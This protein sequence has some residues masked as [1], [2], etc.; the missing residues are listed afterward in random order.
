MPYLGQSRLVL[1]VR[2][3]ALGL[4]GLCRV[5]VATAPEAER[6]RLALF[7][8]A[9]SRHSPAFACVS[10]DACLSNARFLCLEV[11]WCLAQRACRWGNG[12]QLE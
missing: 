11:S 9:R 8:R 1:Q 10:W 2:L 4:R 6:A 3:A 5:F 12:W 7:V